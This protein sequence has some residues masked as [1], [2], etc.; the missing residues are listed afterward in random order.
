MSKSSFVTIMPA[1]LE[2]MLDDGPVSAVNMKTTSDKGALKRNVYVAN[3]LTELVGVTVSKSYLKDLI[4]QCNAKAYPNQA[5][6]SNTMWASR[7]VRSFIKSNIVVE[8]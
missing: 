8:S 3:V 6:K 1:T 7:K 5:P 4:A 2:A